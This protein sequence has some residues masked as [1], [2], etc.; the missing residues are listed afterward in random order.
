MFLLCKKTGNF[1]LHNVFFFFVVGFSKRISAVA[2]SPGLGFLRV[3]FLLIV[4]S[5]VVP[6]PRYRVFGFGRGFCGLWTVGDH[7]LDLA[8]GIGVVAGAVAVAVALVLG[9]GV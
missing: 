5:R 1:M 8:L 2:Y 9:S 4:R 3:R 6:D 7:R